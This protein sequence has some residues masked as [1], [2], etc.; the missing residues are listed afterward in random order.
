VAFGLAN[1]PRAAKIHVDE[2]RHECPTEAD[3]S[4]NDNRLSTSE[5]GRASGP[6]GVVSSVRAMGYVRTMKLG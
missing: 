3:N 1:G 4:E 2:A 6:I 5:G